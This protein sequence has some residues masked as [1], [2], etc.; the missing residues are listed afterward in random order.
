VKRLGQFLEDGR[1]FF[2]DEL[3]YEPR[4]VEKHLQIAGMRAHL[5]ALGDA[6]DATSFDEASLEAALRQLAD[7]RAIKAAALIHATRVAVTGKAASPGLFEVLVLLGRE[8]IRRRFKRAT[9]LA[10]M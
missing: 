5:A 9:S 1:F 7:A 4:A 3:S 8:R 10:A 2:D 6:F